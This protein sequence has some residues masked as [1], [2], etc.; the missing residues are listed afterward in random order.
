MFTL[1]VVLQR[2]TISYLLGSYTPISVPYSLFTLIN[3]TSCCSSLLLPK[4]SSTPAI[5]FQYLYT[6][7]ITCFVTVS[8][9][10]QPQE[11]FASLGTRSEQTS[12]SMHHRDSRFSIYLMY[13]TSKK[14][15][16]SQ[17]LKQ[18][19]FNTPLQMANLNLQSIEQPVEHAKLLTLHT[20]IQVPVTF[21]P[22]E[23]QC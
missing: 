6:C 13:Q 21:A 22:F 4:P 3:Q 5:K 2:R 8:N 12:T 18:T 10:Q 23:T 16:R 11:L 7:E 20:N 17:N 1:K 14:I 9:I 19:K 15:I